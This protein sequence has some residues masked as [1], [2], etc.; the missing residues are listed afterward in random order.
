VDSHPTDQS[1]DPLHAVPRTLTG[2]GLTKAELWAGGI[3][4][5]TW[6]SM[7]LIMFIDWVIKHLK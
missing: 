1:E 2:N 3:F 4:I 7:D 6:F 5:F